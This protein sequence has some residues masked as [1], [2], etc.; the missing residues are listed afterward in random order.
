MRGMFPRL[1][2]GAFWEAVRQGKKPF[3]YK[4]DTI[5]PA[6]Q[7]FFLTIWLLCAKMISGVALV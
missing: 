6:K 1:R 5:F 3:P 7:Y 2:A 4:F